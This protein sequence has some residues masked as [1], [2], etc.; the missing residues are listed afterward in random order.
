[1]QMPVF[2]IC[3]EMRIDTIYGRIFDSAW[4]SKSL[5]HTGDNS[6]HINRASNSR[7]SFHPIQFHLTVTQR[8]WRSVFIHFAIHL[9]LVATFLTPKI[10][11]YFHGLPCLIGHHS[12]VEIIESSWELEI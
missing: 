6:S 8:A 1:M 10:C 2:S 7:H 9:N 5:F 3:C 12:G 11:C 4:G